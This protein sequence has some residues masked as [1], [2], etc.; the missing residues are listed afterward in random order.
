VSALNDLWEVMKPAILTIPV[1]EGTERILRKVFFMGAAASL[2]LHG[3]V[4]ASEH[5]A[6]QASLH[7]LEQEISATL[8]LPEEN[9]GE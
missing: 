5:K 6:T 8:G 1:S 9:G 3:T 4:Q 2:T 7:A